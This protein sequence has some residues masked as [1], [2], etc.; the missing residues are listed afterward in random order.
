MA[1]K[2]EKAKVPTAVLGVGAALA[3]GAAVYFLTRPKG[4]PGVATVNISTTPVSGQ[5]FLDGFSVGNAPLKLELGEIG[6][7]IISFGA[8]SGY[9]TPEDVQVTVE[10]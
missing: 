9:T 4:K 6:V 2:E 1:D 7:Y 10:E 3:A 5:V 8:V